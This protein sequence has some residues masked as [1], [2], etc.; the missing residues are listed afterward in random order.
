MIVISSRVLMGFGDGI[1]RALR[2]VS[3]VK[4]ANKGAGSTNAETIRAQVAV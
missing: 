3:R 2:V 1:A 4:S